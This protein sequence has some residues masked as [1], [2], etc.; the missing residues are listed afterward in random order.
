MVLPT[1]KYSLDTPQEMCYPSN[2][3]LP[4]FNPQWA[5]MRCPDKASAVSRPPSGNSTRAGR[6]ALPPNCQD[7]MLKCSF[8]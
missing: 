8:V 4:R 5:V 1:R 3:A 2:P 7:P 6:K